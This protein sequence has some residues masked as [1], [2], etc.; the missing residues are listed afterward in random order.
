MKTL[1]YAL[2]IFAA[3][4][5]SAAAESRPK[6]VDNPYEVCSKDEMCA[7]GIGSGLKMA[8]A[9]A[10]NNIA[11][12][13]ETR[14]KSTFSSETTSDGD[15]VKEKVSD[16]LNVETDMLIEAVEIKDTYNTKTDVYALAVLNKKT[17]SRL[18]SDDMERLDDKMRALLR[19]DTPASAVALQKA[20][21]QRAALNRRYAVLTGAPKPEAV[22]YDSV[23]GAMKSRVGR[24]HVYLLV[25]GSS[26]FG[27]AVRSVMADNGYTFADEAGKDSPQVTVTF[28]GTEQYMNV[29]GFVKYR[30][31]FTL[32]APDANQVTVTK[33]SSEFETTGRNKSQAEA[34]ALEELKAY[35]NENILTLKL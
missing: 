23:Y 31:D 16:Y 15:K 35:L 32:K 34:A 13:F 21:E 14:V 19:D 22:G 3:A 2:G 5:S 12:I 8:R 17:A 27:N 24:R 25:K 1:F 10:R 4:C 26:A 18:T 11:K 20:Y 6:W 29:P 9:D 28:N 30:Y 33:L 7:V